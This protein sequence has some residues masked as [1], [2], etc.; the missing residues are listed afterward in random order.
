MLDR[1]GVKEDET[2]LL[3]NFLSILFFFETGSHYVP[4]AGLKLCSGY[5]DQAGLKLIWIRLPLPLPPEC[6]DYVYSP[7]YLPPNQNALSAMP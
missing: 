6:W 4:M 1:V 5:V 2:F 3:W 7:L